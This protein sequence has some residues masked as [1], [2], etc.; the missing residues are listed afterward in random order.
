MSA[1]CSVHFIS[2]WKINETE[3]HFIRHAIYNVLGIIAN[4]SRLSIGIKTKQTKTKTNKKTKTKKK[5]KTKTKN[6]QTKQNKNKQKTAVL[7]SEVSL[8]GL[9][10]RACM[11]KE[12]LITPGVHVEIVE[13]CQAL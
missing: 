6:K 11:L 13:L 3:S 10:G 4:I 5:H 8:H 9:I 2:I 1:I 7:F 12:I